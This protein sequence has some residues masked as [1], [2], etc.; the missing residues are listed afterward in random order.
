MFKVHLLTLSSSKNTVLVGMEKLMSRKRS[1]DALVQWFGPYVI[2][3]I[4][5][6]KDEKSN[7]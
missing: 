6:L 2:D 5:R 3:L 1:F 7:S 4:R